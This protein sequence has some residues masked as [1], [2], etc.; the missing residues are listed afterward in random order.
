[1]LLEWARR[2]TAFVGRHRYGRERQEPKNEPNAIPVATMACDFIALVGE[3]RVERR[4][5]FG[6]IST[7]PPG[8]GTA[9]PQKQFPTG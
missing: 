2:S 8:V 4:R 6:R 5:L 1:M 3:L 7:V 9:R